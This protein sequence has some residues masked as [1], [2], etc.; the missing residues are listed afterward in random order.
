M[1][2]KVEISNFLGIK[3][4]SFD[5]GKI[6]I[7]KG[8]SGSG[9]SSFLEAINKAFDSKNFE[10]E[11][12][13][14][15]F[16]GKDEGIVFVKIE[17]DNKEIEIKRTITKE[18]KT[19][20]IE[21]K[22]DG[23]LKSKPETFLKELFSI[24]N[25]K[26]L[27]FLE[28]S[29]ADQ[30]ETFLSL[31]D[32]E[33]SADDCYNKFGVIP[34]KIDYKEHGLKV[35]AKLETFWNEK[36]K[37]A[38]TLLKEKKNK[39]KTIKEELPSGFIKEVWQNKDIGEM[40]KELSDKTLINE[41]INTCKSMTENFNKIKTEIINKYEADFIIEKEKVIEKTL[42]EKE[43]IQTE[44]VANEKEITDL[45]EEIKNILNKIT[46]LKQKNDSKK[47][48][49]LSI[50]KKRDEEINYIKL[51]IEKN[52]QNDI[53]A[54]E[55]KN[56]KM[57][58]YLDKNKE[59][60]QEKIEILKKDIKTAE[61]MK[62]FVKVA[63]N[64]SVYEKEAE[65]LFQ[66]V[67]IYKSNIEFCKNEPENILKT[68]GLPV[69]GLFI[70]DNLL[71]YKDRPLKNLSTGEKL[72]VVINIAKEL[73]KNNPLKIINID[74]IQNVSEQLRNDF[75]ATLENDDIQY[76]L[77]ETVESDFNLIRSN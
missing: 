17:N 26:P 29:N 38:D 33:F 20:S 8:R 28:L 25:F 31:I 44:I 77:T 21:V 68:K 48:V 19:S 51:N 47:D 63:E 61:D 30:I 76:F 57:L 46:L 52:Q 69:V 24:N 42:K 13:T 5:L 23:I 54:L 53:F 41:R 62:G 22:E 59:V 27:Q 60:S 56:V 7:L 1:I 67:N 2:I 4:G 45:E 14:N 74:G 65:E 40:Y 34:P 18:G 39:I 9:K 16:T 70:K 3:E 36:R 72:V 75:L 58:Q 55:E 49:L 37:E 35:L 71:W 10:R 32:Y 73:I 15:L 11:V 66:N 43:L 64:L 12:A 6:N 50:D